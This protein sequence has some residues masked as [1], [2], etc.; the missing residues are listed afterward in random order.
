[1]EVF[2]GNMGSNVLWNE[3]YLSLNWLV[4][5]RLHSIE[6]HDLLDNPQI[7]TGSIFFFFFLC[8]SKEE[9]KQFASLWV[10]NSD[11]VILV[12]K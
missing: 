8:L 12:R 11:E 4:F 6:W 9:P 1:M 3:K 7:P 10:T 5:K 2:S